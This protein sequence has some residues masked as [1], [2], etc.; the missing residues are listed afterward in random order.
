M[1]E[2]RAATR[3]AVMP[4][5]DLLAFFAAATLALLLIVLFIVA[6]TLEHGRRGGRRP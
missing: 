4:S 5:P 6:R 1:R 3:I 2:H